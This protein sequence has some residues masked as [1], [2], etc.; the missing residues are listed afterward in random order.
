M[1]TSRSRWEDFARDDP[2]FFILTDLDDLRRSGESRHDAF[3]RS[4]RET[5]SVLMDAAAPY[6]EE[7][8]VALEIGAGLGRLALAV[9]PSFEHMRAVDLSETMLG[10]LGE[11]AADKGIE[12]LSTYLPDQDW[13]QPESVDFAYSYLV[14]Q[15][16]QKTEVIERYLKLIGTTLKP[17]GCALL[18]FDTRGQSLGYRLRNALPDWSLPRAQRRGIR[19]IRRSADWLAERMK[20]A[21]LEVR[22]EQRAQSSMHTYIVTRALDGAQASAE[23]IVTLPAMERRRASA[24]QRSTAEVAAVIK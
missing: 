16:I 3:Y 9:A 2:E 6:H 14:F 23:R 15:H 7:R 11:R 13:S 19:R 18:Q 1:R 5:A 12:N 8:G 21:G 17:T 24:P 22:E 10:M 4:G 20:E